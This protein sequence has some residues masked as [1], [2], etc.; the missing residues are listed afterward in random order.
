MQGIGLLSVQAVREQA[1]NTADAM[2]CDRLQKI[3][4][5]AEASEPS[6]EK[7][8]RF[9]GIKKYDGQEFLMGAGSGKNAVISFLRSRQG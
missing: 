1:D 2:P 3:L 7:S 8:Q 4:S 9:C 6:E 5:H